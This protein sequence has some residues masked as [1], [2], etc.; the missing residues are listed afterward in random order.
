MPII[1]TH[2]ESV[3]PLRPDRIKKKKK[4]VSDADKKS[5]KKMVK[6]LLNEGAKNISDADRQRVMDT[7]M[8]KNDGGMVSNTRVY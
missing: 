7:Y 8:N 4:N 1:V 5:A 3:G 6:K 2:D